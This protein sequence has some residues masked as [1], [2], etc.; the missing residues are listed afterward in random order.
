LAWVAPVVEE[1]AL[2]AAANLETGDGTVIDLGVLCPPT[3]VTWRSQRLMSLTTHRY[4]EAGPFI[5]RLHWGAEIVEAP[6]QPGLLPGPVE[7]PRPEVALFA[8]R[9]PPHQPFQRTVS[10]KVVGLGSE[11]QVRLDSGAG[12]TYTLSGRLGAEQA[13]GW[14]LDY[15]KPGLYTVGLDLLDADGF[16][17]AV[18]AETPIEVSAVVPLSPAETA[19]VS[20]A[21]KPAETEV[22]PWAPAG[23]AG[24]PAD[25][26]TAAGETQPWLPYRY[27]RP[28]WGSAR[29]YAGPGGGQVT[30]VVSN[31]YLGIRAETS[32]GGATWYQTAGG[33]WVAAEA[34]VLFVPSE[35]RG[36]ELGAVSPPPPPPPPEPPAERQGI[37]T[38]DVLNVRASPGV[39]PDNPPIDRLYSGATVGIYEETTFAGEVWYRIGVGRWVHSN[40]V[41]VIGA[42]PPPPPEPE[43]YGIVTADVLNVRASPGVRSDNPPIDRLTNG[44]QVTIYEESSY[45][46][47]TW[48]RIGTGRWVYGGYVMLVSTPSPQPPPALPRGVVTAD[49]L[50]VRAQPGVRADNPPV[51]QLTAGT[52]VTIYEETDVGGVTWYRIGPDRWVHG[53]WI[54]LLETLSRTVFGVRLVASSAEEVSLPVGWVVASSLNVRGRPGVWDGNPPV[55]QVVHNQVVP[56]LDTQYVDGSPWY[57]IGAD[58]W[59]EGTWVG[60]ARPKPRPSSIRPDERWVGVNLSEQTVVCYEGE[61]PVYAAL[62]ATGLPGTPTVQGIFRTWQRLETGVMA[63]PGYYIEDVTWTCY[64]YSGYGLHTAYWHDAFGRP[65][66]HGCVNL[67]PYDAWWIYQWSAPAGPNSPAV[68]VYW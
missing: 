19:P 49:V 6:V 44:T 10:V 5:A 50:N 41:R 61:R 32:V 42:Q 31:T 21:P 45:A 40:W 56:I 1:F 2:G 28:A 15:A 48:Y 18:L 58:R 53:G 47:E 55:D 34:V 38:A 62:A 20:P 68:Y 30:R 66:S 12:Q 3:A 37:V 57:R 59:V 60:C 23:P 16:W 24:Q 8:V 29:L 26:S 64:F 65:R 27:C 33:D 4:T 17:L 14:T 67:S 43:R 46:G 22:E 63:G 7:P 54:R 51:A 39:R 13:G 36:V 11:Q 35:L 9:M 52:E 25:V